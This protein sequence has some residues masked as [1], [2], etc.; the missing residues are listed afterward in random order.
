MPTNLRAVKRA[1]MEVGTNGAME[2][3]YRE[4]KRSVK[5]LSPEEDY[6]GQGFADFILDYENETLGAYLD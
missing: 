2:T 1:A 4:K 6:Q 3:K 5:T